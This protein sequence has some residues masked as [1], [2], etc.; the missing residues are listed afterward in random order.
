MFSEEH[1][2]TKKHQSILEMSVNLEN[3]TI[4][5]SREAFGGKK[6]SYGE[7]KLSM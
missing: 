1:T 4:G 3:A 6:G 2:L 7:K 5:N